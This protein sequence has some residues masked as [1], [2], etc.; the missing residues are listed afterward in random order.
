MKKIIILS[1][2]LWVTVAL[3]AQNFEDAV[4]F[5]R[6]LNFGT[7]RSAGMAGAFGA[8]GGDLSTLNSN[9]AGVGVFRKSEISITPSL[10]FANTQATAFNAKHNS[11]QLGNIGAVFA[12][13]SPEFD[14]K[15]INFGINYTN[16]NNF[17]RTTD[18]LISNSETSWLDVLA[19][20]SGDYP[21]DELNIF[22]NYPAYQCWLLNRNEN[23]E[24]PD[25]G[26]YTAILPPGELVA[27]TKH[28]KEDGN[29]GE[30]AFSFGTNYKDK[31]YLGLTLGIQSIW[32]KMQSEYTEAPPEESA[33]GLDYYTFYDYKK[34]N[35]VGTNL[36]FGIIYRPI[37]E[38]RIGAAIHTPTWYNMNYKMATSMYSSFWTMTDESNGRDGYDFDFQSPEY[39]VDFNMRTPWRAIVSLATVL[40][41][42]AIIS[43]DYEYVDYKNASFS[44]IED[45]NTLQEKQVNQEIQDYLRAT[46]NFR[47]GA[48]Y[49]FNK[50]FSLRA[51][52][53]FWDS[54]YRNE[55]HKNHNRL[56]AFTAGAGLNFGAFYCNAAY[57]HKF[58]ENKTVFY[59]F[60]EIQSEPVKNQYLGNEARLTFGVRF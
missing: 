49:R 56:Q 48:E 32:Y 17:N 43:A 31:L 3:Q 22:M 21:S 41:Q 54:P 59:S 28:I 26:Y 40:K 12:F 24:D 16:L 53:A 42:K 2:F 29:Q 20:S 33:S 15:G 25:F 34:M 47:I 4:Q 46:H 30:Y 52:Y 58:S 14:W 44:E 50:I 6:T 18:Q 19:A 60:D 1:V 9:P 8:L 7:A 37:P 45:Y 38:I 13:H 5:S 11:F 23:E 27:Q 51:G 35:G 55:I 39:S 10:N 36:K 57:I